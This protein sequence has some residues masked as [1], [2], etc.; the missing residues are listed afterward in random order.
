M[1]LTKFTGNN[2]GG[3][4]RMWML[5]LSQFKRPTYNVALGVYELGNAMAEFSEIYFQPDSCQYAIEEKTAN[6][7]DFSLTA[8]LPKVRPDM[9]KSARSLTTVPFVLLIADNNGQYLLVG[10]KIDYLLAQVA[11]QP[12]SEMADFNHTAI[13]IDRNLLIMPL[14]VKDPY[15]VKFAGY[16]PYLYQNGY[17]NLGN[18][19]YV[20]ITPQT[21]G[22]IADAVGGFTDNA[23][24]TYGYV[25]NFHSNRDDAL[26]AQNVKLVFDYRSTFQYTTGDVVLMKMVVL[27][28]AGSM[29]VFTPFELLHDN[30]LH[31]VELDMVVPEGTTM[32]DIV[33]FNV[34]FHMKNVVEGSSITVTNFE[35]WLKP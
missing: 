12:G 20:L 29:L 6:A 23:N 1:S 5:P 13:K 35:I 14:F 3:C 32:L 30:E 2:A 15:A 21:S 16:V 18:Q 11:N 4:V 10:N 17:F 31:H 8:K 27:P 24:G 9:A 22:F 34:N 7:I 26:V 28:V 33:N 19:D 25:A